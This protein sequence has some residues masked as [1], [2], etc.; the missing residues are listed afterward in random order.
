[1]FLK[2]QLQGVADLFFLYC[3]LKSQL[4]DIFK[5]IKKQTLEPLCQ[6]FNNVG[7]EVYSL[8]EKKKSNYLKKVLNYVNVF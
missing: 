3:T 2:Q 5:K 4:A 6:V 7:D 1:M 8:F